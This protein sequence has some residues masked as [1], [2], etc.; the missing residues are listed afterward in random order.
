M[1]NVL[2]TGVNRGLGY[3]LLKTF[4]EKGDCVFGLLQEADCVEGLL[5]QF[6]ERFIPIIGDVAQDCVI[7]RV[8]EQISRHTDH[9]DVLINNAGVPGEAGSI[10]TVTPE[11]MKAVM[12]VNCFG[13]LRIT[14]AALPFM[15][16]SKKAVVVNLSSRMASLTQTA[17]GDYWNRSFSYA[18]RVSK[19][20]QNMLT[21]CMNEELKGFGIGIAA[22]HP[23]KLNTRASSTNADMTI[24]EGA[25]NL[26]R[27]IDSMNEKDHGRF[28]YP[29]VEEYPW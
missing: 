1:K 18:Y 12:E 4:V 20:A 8:Q 2:I 29:F 27:F 6:P 5:A 21:I 14:Q 19:A 16:A 15:K 26:Y 17:R 7:G 24:E 23:G 9:L 28:L 25:M 3:A 11:E 22:V 10:E 13:V